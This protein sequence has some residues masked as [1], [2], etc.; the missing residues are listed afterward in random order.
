[1]GTFKVG[2]FLTL[3]GSALAVQTSGK[4][5]EVIGFTSIRLFDGTTAQDILIECSD[6]GPGPEDGKCRLKVERYTGIPGSGNVELQD[7]YEANLYLRW[8]VP[9]SPRNEGLWLLL[10]FDRKGGNYFLRTRYKTDSLMYLRDTNVYK[11]RYMPVSFSELAPR[12]PP[13]DKVTLRQWIER[14]NDWAPD[15]DANTEFFNQ[16]DAFNAGSLAAVLLSNGEGF[17]SIAFSLGFESDA[18]EKALR[19]LLKLRLRPGKA[20]AHLASR[21][22]YH[23]ST[24][25]DP[26]GPLTSSVI[27]W[28]CRPFGLV[29]NP[30]WVLDW[31]D[32]PTNRAHVEL[33]ANWLWGAMMRHYAV[34]LRGLREPNSL[35]FMPGTF[36]DAAH[37]PVPSWCLRYLIDVESGVT[38]SRLAELLPAPGSLRLQL[39]NVGTTANEQVL[40]D[41]SVAPA[42]DRSRGVIVPH[43]PFDLLDLALGPAKSAVQPQ[44]CLIG[45]V[46]LT[47]GK[48]VTPQAGGAVLRAAMRSPVKRLAGQNAMDTQLRLSLQGRLPRPGGQDAERGFESEDV[49]R[50]REPSIVW[51]LSETPAFATLDI[52]ESSRTRQSRRLLIQVRPESQVDDQADAVV[53]D[54]EPFLV[55]RVR[56]VAKAPKDEVFASYLDEP[57]HPGAWEFA[58][59]TGL[60]HVVLPPQAIGEEMIK[61]LYKIPGAGGALIAVPETGKVFDHRLSPPAQLVLKRNDIDTART[62][63][64][65]A[66]RQ[67][68]D[69]RLGAVGVRLLRARFELLYGLTSVLSDENPENP[70]WLRLAEADALVG[71]VP[72]PSDLRPLVLGD[73]PTDKRLSVYAH[74]VQDWI[75]S[76]LRRPAQLPVFRE[77]TARERLVVREGLYFELRQKRQTANPFRPQLPSDARS[78]QT[79]TPLRGGVDWGFESQNIYD[80][81]LKSG[82]AR[83]TE[84]RRKRAA[85]V[86]YGQIAGLEFGAL[87][88]RGSQKAIF[89][90]GKT[91]IISETTQGRLDSLTIVRIGRIAMLFNHARHVIVYERSTR[92]APRYRR[93]SNDTDIADQQPDGFE[94]MSALRKVKEY[95]EV[96]QPRRAYPDYPTA[97]PTNAFFAGVFFETTIIPVKSSWGRDVPG[98]WVMHLRGPMSTAERP[99]YPEP[100]IFGEFSRAADKGGGHVSQPAEMLEL[101][102]FFTSTRPQDGAD[103]DLWPAFPNVDMPLTAKPT[104]PKVPFLPTFAGMSRQPDAEV[105]DFG[106]RQ[107]SLHLK[108]AEEAVNLMHG[109]DVKGLDA[110][111]RTVSIARGAP[112]SATPL[113]KELAE[114]QAK[115][116]DDR[117][118]LVEGLAEIASCVAKQA[119][120]GAVDVDAA[121]PGMRKRLHDMAERAK[122]LRDAATKAKLDADPWKSQQSQLKALAE[123]SAARLLETLTDPLKK[124]A[125]AFWDTLWKTSADS[126]DAAQRIGQRIDALHAQIR[127]QIQSQVSVAQTAVETFSSAKDQALTLALRKRPG[128]PS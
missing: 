60:L 123:K 14:W 53:I 75:Q 34:G 85:D 31:V 47:V 19:L 41:V 105:T 113:P 67:L 92:T 103:T 121:I 73:S 78:A 24:A 10:N 116:I 127:Q 25:E 18:S 11:D 94:G 122:G 115:C 110:R 61:G 13:E 72:L 91:H 38:I 51:D 43:E 96:T 62:L 30:R 9:V 8:P 124:E 104:P 57:G 109:R 111:I 48:A 35:S 46:L 36:A 56:A 83:K 63:A 26:I 101:L 125:S 71:A 119:G 12:N 39:P 16:S 29:G 3:E 44:E 70:L 55:A 120:A 76:L 33:S 99:F 52:D 1:M 58:T 7:G 106:Q 97:V 4:R 65:W 98:G 102:K 126:A 64:P 40:V 82:E 90:N 32:L 37:M 107:F 112:I 86:P 93:R 117:A 80:E 42:R 118:I 59:E 54:V 27:N 66:L 21:A 88:G 5:L 74:N 87:G 128:I 20:G 15:Y 49:W 22:V 89:S 114:V 69:R 23:T 100:K 17:E 45:G 84:E 108:P 6:G 28:E 77:W 81:F 50:Q 95:I 79:R 68:F 2:Q